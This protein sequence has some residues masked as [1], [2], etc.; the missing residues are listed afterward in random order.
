MRDI[1]LRYLGCGALRL[2]EKEE[3]HI[4]MSIDRGVPDLENEAKDTDRADE[5]LEIEES[6]RPDLRK[7]SGTNF[8]DVNYKPYTEEFD[9]IIKAE[10]LEKILISNYFSL[11]ILFLN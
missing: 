3:K 2:K 5:E 9:E 10:D 1:K 7:R 11:K 8:G 6:S 4:E